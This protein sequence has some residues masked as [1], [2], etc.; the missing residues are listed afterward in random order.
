MFFFVLFKFVFLKGKM[1][2]VIG[3]RNG[4]ILH[5]DVQE[6]SQ[7][8]TVNAILP[9]IESFNF[10][11]EIRKQTSGKAIPQLTFSHWEVSVYLFFFLQNL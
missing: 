6:G 7:I 2:A 9:V 5:A 10:V 11:N 8:F 3:R 4:R 1:Y